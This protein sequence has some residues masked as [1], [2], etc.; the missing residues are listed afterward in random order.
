MLSVPAIPEGIRQSAVN[1]VFV[2]Q[3]ALT[4][5]RTHLR[6]V[7]NIAV[8]VHAPLIEAAEESMDLQLLSSEFAMLQQ[9]SNEPDLDITSIRNTT[10]RIYNLCMRHVVVDDAADV[11]SV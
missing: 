1:E 6:L 11:L 5:G 7:L 10:N 8:D 9:L 3:D 2:I 4:Q